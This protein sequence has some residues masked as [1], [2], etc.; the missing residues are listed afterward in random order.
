MNRA[1]LRPQVVKLYESS[2]PSG[3]AYE[4]PTIADIALYAYTHTAGEAGYDVTQAPA[5]GKWLERVRNLDGHIP[6]WGGPGS[7]GWVRD[8]RGTP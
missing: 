3:N 1:M 5:V 6:I 2:I 7:P 8:A 4:R